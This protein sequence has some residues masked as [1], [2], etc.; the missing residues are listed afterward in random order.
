MSAK[1][2]IWLRLDDLEGL[3]ASA[4]SGQ[5][6]VIF[7]QPVYGMLYLQGIW[8]TES[9]PYNGYNALPVWRRLDRWEWQRVIG[10]CS[11][12]LV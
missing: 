9:P 4:A 5:V 11:A 8:V 12:T 2:S 6:R 10:L 1:V 7:C 3:V